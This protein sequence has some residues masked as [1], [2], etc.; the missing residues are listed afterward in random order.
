M[1]NFL[2]KI[3]LTFNSTSLLIVIYWIKE[4]KLIDWSSISPK[5]SNIPH[6]VS[7]GIYFLIPVLLTL[8]SLWLANYLDNDSIEENKI[9][10]VEQ[11]NNAFLPNH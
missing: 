6:F 3:L 5:L 11:A 4:Q 10:E 9:S 7:Y 8:F 2:Y 1:I